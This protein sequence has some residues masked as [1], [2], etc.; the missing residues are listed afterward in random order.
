MPTTPTESLARALEL[1]DETVATVRRWLTEAADP[2]NAGKRDVSA[3]RLAGVLKD[4]DGLAFTIGFVDRV[5][6]PADL[7]VAGRNLEQVSRRVPKFLPLYLRIVIQLG[8]GFA[9]LLPWPIVPIS[10]W[11]FRRMVSHLVLDATPSRLDKNLAKLRERG[12]RL[13]IN[14]LGEAVL[15]LEEA[16]RRLAKTRELLAR[17]DVDYVSIKV[18]A[19][20]GKL[21]MWAYEETVDRVV[22]RLTPLYEQAAASTTTKFIN[23]DMEEFHDLDLTIEVFKK[24]LEKPSLH[25]LEAG[26]VLQAYLPDALRAL[27]GLTEWAIRR[28]AHGGA[29]IKVRVVKGA[30]LAMERVDA[31]LRGWPLA[32]VGSKQEADTNYKRVLSWA[33]TPERTDAVRLGVAGHNLFDIAFAWL[34]AKQ[35]G[36]TARVEFE[37]LLGMARAQA[38]VV[39]K[40]VGGILLYTPVVR[41]NEFNAAIAYLI[42]RLEENA[43]SDNFMS[44]VFE[45]ADNR[46]MFDREKSRF[47]GALAA[48]DEEVPA[49]NR[50]QNRLATDLSE[51]STKS[52]ASPAFTNAPDTD[53]SIAAN[54][55]WGRQL[56]ERSLT[57]RLGEQ[58]VQASVVTTADQLQEV[59]ARTVVAGEAWGQQGAS[60]RAALLHEVG[61][62]LAVYRGRIVEVLVSETGK[63][64]AEADAEASRAIDIAH[65][66]AEQARGLE[67]V[68]NALFVPSRLT[69]VAPPFSGAVAETAGAALA[70]IAAGSGVIVK[71]ANRA[72]RSAALVAEAMW[73]AGVS[74]DLAGVITLG[75]P[76][77]LDK[78]LTHPNVDRVI[79]HGGE[80]LGA[81]YRAIRS[82]RPLIAETSG[83]NAVIV[84]PSADV[85]LAVGH[86]ARGAFS[87]AG[88]DRLASSLVILVGSVA[89]SEQFRR[90]LTD[91]VTSMKVGA[92]HEATTSMGPLAEPASGSTLRALT[93]LD[94]GESWLVEPTRLDAE[95]TL[96]T[97]GVKLGVSPGSAAHLEAPGAPVLGV[98]VAATLDEAIELQNAG[99][100][101]LAA[102]IHSLD[103]AEISTWLARAEAG[104]LFVNRA[105]TGAIVQRQPVGGWGRSSSGAGAKAGGPNYLRTLGEWTPLFADPSSSVKLTGV[106]DD[107]LPV[108]E[109][110]QPSLE[111][112]EFDRVR[113]GAVSDQRAWET[114]YSLS[115]DPAN[116]GVERNV[117][118][119]VPVPVTVRLAEGE[120][121]AQLVRVIAA[122]TRAGAPI[123]VSSAAPLPA[124]LISLF[125]RE[126]SPTTVEGVIVESDVRWDARVRGGDI[127]TERIRII[128]SN[129]AQR[130]LA[131]ALEGHDGV[132]VYGGAVTTSGVLELWPF[133]REQTVSMTAHRYGNPDPQIAAVDL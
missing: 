126:F 77:L 35:R 16:D 10:R 105:T 102:A 2:A 22:E 62:V 74:R 15:G 132:T 44:A 58:T 11:V 13:N 5:V 120:S 45:L 93:V 99:G 71:P 42:R 111:F 75:A 34:L 117:L 133:L 69:V 70:A 51:V 79:V 48:L 108:I 33:M 91:A 106:S 63:T 72:E 92:A 104:N 26:I 66:Y 52:S 25:G 88:Q 89:T 31:T 122:A 127:A 7:R 128:G 115:A 27:Q 97:P 85:D 59:I 118:R 30:N 46:A 64:I 65:Y 116:L 39:K 103:T 114:L 112:L 130:A 29:G 54:R 107:V 81:R 86:I 100:I 113:A 76:E 18:S 82:G 121:Q 17:D 67:S 125:G 68:E 4:P 57:S 38:E 110:A 41:P 60:A 109:A 6:R 50:V 101:G 96:F 131:T 28:R 55:S 3:E 19:L 90:Q 80:Q 8:G 98:M 124:G 1:G 61:D 84:T 53:P 47:L 95:G 23:L 43:S 14:L 119:Y 83:R 78:L 87:H 9:P 123:T 49:T 20:S 37:M 36:V 32:T 40:D 56:L 94:E 129:E 73:E 24:L 12:I 21:G